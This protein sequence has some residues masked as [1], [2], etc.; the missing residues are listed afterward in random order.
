MPVMEDRVPHERALLWRRQS[1]ALEHFAAAAEEVVAA[2]DADTKIPCREFRSALDTALSTMT[3]RVPDRR[4]DVVHILDVIRGSAWRLPVVFVCGLIQ[5][6]FPIHRSEDPILSDRV[7]RQLQSMSLPLRTSVERQ[8][9]EQ[10]LFDV[11]L[12]RGTE[13]V[14]VSYPQLNAKGEP[15]LAS[16]LLDATKFRDAGPAQRVKP[17]PVRSRWT[18]R[19]RSSLMKRCKPKWQRDSVLSARAERKRFLDAPGALGLVTRC[20]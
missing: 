9:E 8:Q 12:T 17:R 4:R 11:A 16:L 3:L 7:R 15:N 19:L 18:N 20:A 1:A 10:F 6:Q 5:G 2:L 14:V 13:Q